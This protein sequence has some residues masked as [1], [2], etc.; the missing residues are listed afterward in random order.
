MTVMQALARVL[1]AT[2]ALAASAIVVGQATSGGSVLL[3]G[4]HPAEAAVLTQASRAERTMPLELTIVLGLRNQAPA[5]NGNPN[6]P[7]ILTVRS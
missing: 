5:L 3:R 2:V 7:S 1:Q 6:D 4:N